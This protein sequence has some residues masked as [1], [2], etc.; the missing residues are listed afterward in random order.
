MERVDPLA[1][2]RRKKP[3]FLIEHSEHE[4]VSPMTHPLGEQTAEFGAL[5]CINIIRTDK[6]CLLR[7]GFIRPCVQRPWT[8]SALVSLLVLC[9]RLVN[10]ASTWKVR[11]SCARPFLSLSA[12]LWFYTDTNYSL[13]QLSLVD[14]RHIFPSLAKSS[15]RFCIVMHTV[16][17]E[18]FFFFLLTRKSRS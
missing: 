15:L 7:R 11:W 16:G 12:R 8:R 18:T 17:V 3:P 1:G 13:L 10:P 9:L 14:L 6:S 5:V 2:K 4:R